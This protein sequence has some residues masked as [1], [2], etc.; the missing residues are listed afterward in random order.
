MAAPTAAKSVLSSPWS[1]Y[2]CAYVSSIHHK[3]ENSPGACTLAY[4]HRLQQRLKEGLDRRQTP[5]R[6]RSPTCQCLAM[7][8]AH[9]PPPASAKH[10]QCQLM[11]KAAQAIA[12][13]FLA[14]CPQ[15]SSRSGQ[16]RRGSHLGATLLHAATERQQ[17]P[18]HDCLGLFPVTRSPCEGRVRW[19][20]PGLL[21]TAARGPAA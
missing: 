12:P 8:D 11:E 19:V 4:L 7:M 5:A 21:R 3:S 9:A 10:A 13:A 6:V 17:V 15:L 2:A 18:K 14:T 1:V 20:W 16:L